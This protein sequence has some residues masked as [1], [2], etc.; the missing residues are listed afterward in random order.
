M[1]ERYTKRGGRKARLATGKALLSRAL[2]VPMRVR[3]SVCGRAE[4]D[5]DIPEAREAGELGR[6]Q[7]RQP[8]AG[9]KEP[10]VVNTHEQRACARACMSADARVS[11]AVCA[12]NPSRRR[13]SLPRHAHARVRGA[14][15]CA[16]VCMHLGWGSE[17]EGGRQRTTSADSL[18]GAHVGKGVVGARCDG[19]VP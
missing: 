17:G 19:L 7:A 9:Q 12:H 2:H 18:E 16:C 3:A 10:P 5:G 1:R 11:R 14:S 6:R 15:V 4:R 8:V 13:M